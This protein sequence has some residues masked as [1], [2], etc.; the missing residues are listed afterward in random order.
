MMQVFRLILR[1][2]RPGL[3]YPDGNSYDTGA[4]YAGCSRD[5]TAPCDPQQFLSEQDAVAYAN[6]RGEVPVRVRDVTQTWNIIAGDEPITDDMIITDAGG[7]MLAN[8]SPVA[9]GALAIGAF[10]LLPKLLGG[11]KGAA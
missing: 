10:F 11:K 4:T 8:L 2:P 6:Q 1:T 5:S 9:V 7:G 3:N